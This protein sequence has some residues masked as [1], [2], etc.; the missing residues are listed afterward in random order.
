MTQL[1]FLTAGMSIMMF[2]RIKDKKF[3][4]LLVSKVAK[5]RKS[6]LVVKVAD[7]NNTQTPFF[8]RMQS[9]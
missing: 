6:T 4:T 3:E 8:K 2:D 7:F 1:V 5:M 9:R